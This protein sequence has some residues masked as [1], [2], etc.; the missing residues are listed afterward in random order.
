MGGANGQIAGS[1]D[2]K[3]L[4]YRNLNRARGERGGVRR[5]ART[6]ASKD[7][8]SRARLHELREAPGAG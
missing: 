1:K 7:S 4:L 8:Q 6:Q 2:V 5:F 3:L